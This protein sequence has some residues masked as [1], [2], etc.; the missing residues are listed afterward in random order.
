MLHRFNQ[1][2]SGED[3]SKDSK[4]RYPRLTGQIVID[5]LKGY[6]QLLFVNDE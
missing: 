6:N 3:I 5:I 4:G 2:K 1:L